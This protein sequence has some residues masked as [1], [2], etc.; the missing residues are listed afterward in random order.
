[1]DRGEW[2]GWL[3]GGTSAAPSERGIRRLVLGVGAT[4]VS[5]AARGPAVG[6]VGI[7]T[8]VPRTELWGWRVAV[9][10]NGGVGIR[11]GVARLGTRAIVG[12]GLVGVGV[13]VGI[14][15]GLAGEWVAMGRG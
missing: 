11:A 1:M 13:G 5:G 4:V 12:V 15:V 14:S 8:K 9:A 7:E 10:T 6:D 3:W 2:S